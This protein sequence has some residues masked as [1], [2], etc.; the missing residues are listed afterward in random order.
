MHARV[1]N[2]NNVEIG[3]HEPLCHE[4]RCVLYS[5]YHSHHPSQPNARFVFLTP[6]PPPA[7]SPLSLFSPPVTCSLAAGR[8]RLKVFESGVRAARPTNDDALK[9]RAARHARHLPAIDFDFVD[10]D[11]DGDMV[12]VK[13]ALRQVLMSPTAHAAKV[14]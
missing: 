5:L 4:P 11:D 13:E 3:P 7:L 6:P 1:R 10:D 14:N 12:K 2:E 9:N 8:R